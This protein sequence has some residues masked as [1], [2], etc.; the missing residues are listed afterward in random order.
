M[1]NG[2]GNGR[3]RINALTVCVNYADF[4]RQTL[5]FNLAH[6]DRLIVVTDMRDAETAAMCKE[7]GVEC[8]RTDSFYAQRAHFAKSAAINLALAKLDPQDWACIFDSDIAF[9]YA[10]RPILDRMSQQSEIDPTCIYGCDRLMVKGWKTWAEFG[11]SLLKFNPHFVPTDH[12]PV[13][14]RLAYAAQDGWVPIGYFQLEP[15]RERESRISRRPRCRRGRRTFRAEVAAA[16]ARTDSRFRVCPSQ[17]EPASAMG[18]NW[19][20]RKTIRFEAPPSDSPMAR[21]EPQ[22]VR[23]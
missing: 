1:K 11:P 21:R 8:L 20:G 5:P 17:S 16:K 9:Y 15:A 14:G 7:L 6:F 10:T 3:M 4:L 2:Y 12:L 23:P 22:T 13:G 18:K 19:R